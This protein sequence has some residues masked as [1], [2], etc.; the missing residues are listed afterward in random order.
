MRQVEGPT[1]E[2]QVAADRWRPPVAAGVVVVAALLALSLSRADRMPVFSDL[3]RVVAVGRGPAL[4]VAGLLVWRRRPAS[5]V[6]P[7]LTLF[8]LHQGLLP[9]LA[10]FRAPVPYTFGLTFVTWSIPL[11]WYALLAFPGERLTRPARGLLAA[12]VVVL[13]GCFTAAV[14][15]L[16]PQDSTCPDCPRGLNLLLVSS[17]PDLVLTIERATLAVYGVLQVVL[18]VLLVTRLLRARGAALRVLA[19]A[20]VPGAVEIA[21]D[22]LQ[23][24]DQQLAYA[25]AETYLDSQT[26]L[27][28]VELVTAF[29]LA[30]GLVVGVALEARR[31]DRATT[32]AVVGDLQEGV[33]E[34]LGD[35][36]AR[37]LDVEPPAIR[38][39]TVVA[40]G[41]RW[42]EC[43]SDAVDDHRLLAAV[44]STTALV[45]RTRAQVEE[46]ERRTEE[47]DEARRRLQSAGEQARWEVERD[48]A[49]GPGVHLR[50][51]LAAADEALT[52]APDPLRPAVEALRTE[53]TRSLAELDD[54]AA[55]YALPAG[56]AP[57]LRSLAA[58]KV[59]VPDRR[60]P[61]ECERV[62]WF[63]A[64]EAVANARKHAP[65]SHVHLVVDDSDDL[66]LA[67]RDDGPGNADASGSGLAGLRERVEALGGSLSVVSP[68]GGG[69]TVS[70]VL[71]A[72]RPVEQR[73]RQDVRR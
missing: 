43:Q 45:L 12:V 73:P 65:G 16:E 15:F 10:T 32:L 51:A 13:V 8:G 47:I 3:E 72:E 68:P 64:A 62:G 9:V 71:P 34:A 66:L 50:E 48:L 57:A 42:L 40:V 7:A 44:L 63:V 23:S 25:S 39:R 58:D 37:L 11:L 1:V 41:D 21:G 2:Q 18:L 67:V 19:P 27:P 26:Y 4:L 31:R 59:D 20:L 29:W 46:L 5:L 6:G 61:T 52:A 55:G 54:L 28:W 24:V 69:T 17:R 22:V 60:W 14:P 36:T 30:V 49:G 33:R 38:G 70:A 35:R 53:V 56:L